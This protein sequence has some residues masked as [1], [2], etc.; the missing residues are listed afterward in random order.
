MTPN[1]LARISRA[2]LDEA[3]TLLEGLIESFGRPDFGEGVR[4]F[5]EKRSPRFERLTA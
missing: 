2:A 5:I 1:P 3:R 4:S